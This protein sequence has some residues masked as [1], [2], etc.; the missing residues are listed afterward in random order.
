M[1]GPRTLRWLAK[2]MAKSGGGPL[3][4]RQ[5]WRTL[6]K[7]D[8]SDRAVHEHESICLALEMGGS[9]DQLDCGSCACF[10]VLARRLQLI[11]DARVISPTAPSYDGAEHWMGAQRRKGGSL[12]APELGRCVAHQIRDKT[13]VSKE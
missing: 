10:E 6:C 4:H 1:D 11:E 8:E 9:Y 2:E 7:A 12:I 13:E 5:N 3:R